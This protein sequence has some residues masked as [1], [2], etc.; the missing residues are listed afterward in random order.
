MQCV[1]I[2]ILI[3]EVTLGCQCLGYQ[4]LTVYVSVKKLI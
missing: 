2:I 1:Q 4:W 3:L